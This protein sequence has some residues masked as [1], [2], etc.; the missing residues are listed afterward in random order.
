MPKSE[1][2]I[3]LVHVHQAV[4]FGGSL[5]TY[6][7]SSPA[8]GKVFA[9]FK[10]RPDIFCVEIFNKDDRVLVPLVNVAAMHV[11][12]PRSVAKEEEKKKEAKK[13]KSTLRASDIKKP[14]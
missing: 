11:E 8:P 5:A 10:L 7:T 6:F 12:S 13:P 3:I 2:K 9:E 14:N 1:D 4:R